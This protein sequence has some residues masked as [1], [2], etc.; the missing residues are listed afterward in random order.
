MHIRLL[1]LILPISFNTFSQDKTKFTLSDTLKGSR[2]E[3]RNWNLLHYD[4]TIE[5]NLTDK[6]LHGINIIR[7]NQC[8]TNRMQIDMMEPMEIDSIFY[9]KKKS[10]KFERAGNVFWV[11]L[12][13]IKEKGTSTIQIYFHGKPTQAKLP[14]WTGGWIWKKDKEGNPW[15][16]VA[17]QGEG[18]SIWFPGKDAQYD[19]P[20]QGCTLRIIVPD[21]LSGIGNGKMISKKKLPEN[22][23]MYVWKV[24]NPI[25]HYNIV[26]YI[27]KYSHFGENYKGLKGKL[28]LDYWVLSYNLSSAKKQFTE[29]PRMMKAFEYWFGPYPFYEDGYK[30]VESPHLGME[31]QSNIAYGNQYKN[32]YLGRDL[33]NSGQGLKWDFIIVHESGHEWFGNNITAS[34]VADNWIHEGFTDYSETLFTEYYFGKDAANQYITGLQGSIL[35][36]KPI[37]GIYG[38]HEEGSGDMYYKGANLL[39]TIRQVI[40]DDSLF[41]KILIGLNKTFYHQTVSTKDI[42]DFISTQSGKNLSKIFDQYL[43][44]TD[45]PELYCEFGYNTLTYQWQQCVTDFDMPVKVKIDEG[46]YIWLYPKTKS[47]TIEI[48]GKEEHSILQDNNFYIRMANGTPRHPKDGSL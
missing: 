13:E 39:H 20:E 27:G 37:I 44:T 17:C 1:L 35:N 23:M 3:G 2:G 8:K 48:K 32:G 21:S 29:V 40:H 33:S 45:I 30:L 9:D 10:V 28:T 31:H 41:R 7:F 4:L 5:P 18:S 25:N 26:P 46:D 43:L 36:D 15:A 11:K 38:V 14:P 12:P 16:S 47:Q 22:K 19:E 6:T 34:D 24:K 42:E